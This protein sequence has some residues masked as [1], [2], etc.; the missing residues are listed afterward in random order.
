MK[1]QLALHHAAK[2]GHLDMVKFLVEKG[3][4]YTHKL[5]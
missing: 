2:N 1:G 5:Q 4:T 3:K